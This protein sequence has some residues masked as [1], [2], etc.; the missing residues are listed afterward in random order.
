MAADCQPVLAGKRALVIGG[1]GGGIGSA[2]TRGLATAGAA[3][4]VSDLD[5]ER[6]AE[7][8]AQVAAVGPRAVS[9]T[10]DVRSRADLD[11]LVLTPIRSLA[12]LT[13]WSPSSAGRWRLPRRRRCT[14]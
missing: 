9:L 12:G 14:R 8:A 10:G 1:G 3:V 7:A 13:S 11:D 2:I 6:A 4:A 5:R